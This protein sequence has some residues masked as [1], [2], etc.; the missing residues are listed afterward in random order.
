M[1]YHKN[2]VKALE[3]RV[4]DCIYLMREDDE[5]L[6]VKHLLLNTVMIVQSCKCRPADMH[7]AECVSFAP[8]HYI[9]Q[10]LPVMDGVEVEQFNGR[11]RYDKCVKILLLY[12]IEGGVEVQKMLL[13]GVF[14]IVCFR[15]HKSNIHLQGSVTEQP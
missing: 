1:G 3:K 7:R 15:F 10:L 2:I 8:L 12:L 5:H 6:L 14:L 11:T 13:L 9:A 4:V